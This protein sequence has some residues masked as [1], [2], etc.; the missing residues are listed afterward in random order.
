MR[1]VLP[2]LLTWAC[3]AWV[4]AAQQPP[5]AHGYD[6]KPVA[7]SPA[8]VPGPTPPPGCTAGTLGA[9]GQK[10]VYTRPDLATVSLTLPS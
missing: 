1:S 7:A 9:R 10:T 4:V 8:P 6:Q 3:V 5:G 2:S